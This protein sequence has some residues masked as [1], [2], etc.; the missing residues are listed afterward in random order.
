MP[1]D[2]ITH[3]DRDSKDSKSA[4]ISHRM[5]I[6]PAIGQRLGSFYAVAFKRGGTLKLRLN[7]A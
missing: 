6:I 7:S 4:Q 5:L 2:G 1:S 3:E